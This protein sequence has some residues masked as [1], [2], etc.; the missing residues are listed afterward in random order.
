M[1]HLATSA[2]ASIDRPVTDV[3]IYT[4]PYERTLHGAAIEVYLEIGSK[5]FKGSKEQMLEHITA[6][7]R[8]FKAQH[9]IN[10]DV[11]LSVVEMNWCFTLSA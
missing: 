5:S 2:A 3:A 7:Y 8:E 11:N 6:A 4:Y 1:D 10:L 9:H